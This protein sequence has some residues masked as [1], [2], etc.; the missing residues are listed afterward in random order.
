MALGTVWSPYFIEESK[1]VGSGRGAET[2]EA[3]TIAGVPAQPAA[4]VPGRSSHPP[5]RDEFMAGLGDRRARPGL[6]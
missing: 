4:E 3:L 1:R 2:D 5:R 6:R